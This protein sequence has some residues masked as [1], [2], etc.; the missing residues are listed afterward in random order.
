MFPSILLYSFSQAHPKFFKAHT[1][2]SIGKST[3]P[4]RIQEVAMRTLTVTAALFCL[5]GAPRIQAQEHTPIYQVTVVQRSIQAINYGHRTEPT[6]IDF[7]GTVLMSKAKGEAVVHAKQ[8][9]TSI[10]AKFEHVQ[11]PAKFGPQ[12]LTY[13]MWAITPDGRAINLGE[14]V[15]DSHENVR[16]KTTAPFQAFGL[17]VTAEPYYAVT[18][19]SDLVILQNQPRPDTVGSVEMVKAKYDL[20][21]RSQ[22]TYDVKKAE[23][24]LNDNRRKVSTSEYDAIAAIYQAQNALGIAKSHGADRYASDVYR[25]AQDLLSQAQAFRDKDQNSKQIITLAREATQTAQDALIL[26]TKRS[27][28]ETSTSAEA[29]PAPLTHPATAPDH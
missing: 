29:R 22:Y 8:G 15:P 18:R 24:I 10:D 16:I 2:R 20:L 23:S 17:I 7:Q 11:E 28:E 5:C 25:K 6:R 26:A 14:V 19:P 9:V 13:V 3:A 1:A 4:S 12:F 21:P 27:S